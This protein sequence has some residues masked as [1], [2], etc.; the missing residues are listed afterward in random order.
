MSRGECAKLGKCQA[1]R[2]TSRHLPLGSAPLARPSLRTAMIGARRL[3]KR[4]A[5]RGWAVRCGQQCMLDKQRS[6]RGMTEA[7]RLRLSVCLMPT[8]NSAPRR[9]PDYAPQR[10]VSHRSPPHRLSCAESAAR[11]WAAPAT[12]SAARAAGCGSCRS[13]WALR[14]HW[15]SPTAGRARPAPRA[16]R[17][18]G[19]WPRLLSPRTLPRGARTATEW[20]RRETC[21]CL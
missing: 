21:L 17:Q 15:S 1:Q 12:A 19:P 18:S 3:L 5:R 7:P 6:L 10:Y 13:R 9:A 20:R 4:V 11:P 16:G 2:A 8:V 14:L